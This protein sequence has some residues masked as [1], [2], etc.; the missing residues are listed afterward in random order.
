VRIK[1]NYYMISHLVEDYSI[2]KSKKKGSDL[3]VS[4]ITG[5]KISS[6]IESGF[7]EG[8]GIEE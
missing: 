2:I 1:E 4:K 5:N 7:F 6:P 8:G 3:N